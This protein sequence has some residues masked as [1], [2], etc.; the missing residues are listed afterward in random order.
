MNRTDRPRALKEQPRLH[1]AG[2]WQSPFGTDTI[3]VRSPATGECLGMAAVA[4]EADVRAAADAAAAAAGAWGRLDAFERMHHLHGLAAF[5]RP[6]IG[7]LAELESA[8]TGRPIREM[9]AQMNRLPEWLE[10]FGAIS[11]GLEGEANRVKGG[12][13]TLTEYEPLGVCALLTSWN[14]PILILVKKLAAAL[15][16]GNVCLVKPSELTPLTTLLLADWTREAGL[17]LGVVNV[18]TGAGRTGALV[19]AAEPVK[20]IDLTG[21][22]ATGRLVAATASARLIPCSLELGGKAPILVFDDV[23]IEEAAAGAVFAAFVAAG[24]TCVSGTR[25]LVSSRIHNAFI[26]A[27]VRRAKALRIGAPTDPGTDIGPLI[28]AESRDRCLSY[29][30]NAQEQGAR[31]LCGGGAPELPATL[32]DGYYIQPTIFAD[33]APDMQ[34]FREEVFGPVVSVTAFQDE[35]DALRLANDTVFALGAAVWTRDVARAHRVASQVRAGVIWVND[36][37]KNDPRSIWGGYDESGYGKENGWDALKSRMRKRSIIVRTQP[38]FDD[39]F[40][41]G[42]R[43]G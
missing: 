21:G 7:V 43:Y 20:M 40:G 9:R 4:E 31:L 10:Y 6:R 36:H 32:S 17:P 18:V 38:R 33:V 13:V 42:S 11:V 34:L 5:I 16:A 2:Q 23:D 41:G 12:F 26:D 15:A 14:H 25:F 8:M 28:S 27:F 35:H 39:W 22:T 3:E 29:I 37:H 1:Y 30:A 24:Q 19:C